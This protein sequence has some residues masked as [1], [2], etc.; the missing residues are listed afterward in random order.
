MRKLVGIMAGLVVGYLLGAIAGWLLVEAFSGNRHDRS[1]EIV[2]TSLLVSGPA[3]AV[4]GA[5]LGFAV[6]RR[7]R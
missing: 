5:I 3:G 4:V 2:M 7:S 6:G 1:L